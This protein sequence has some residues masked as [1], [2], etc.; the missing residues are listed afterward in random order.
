ML[1]L[2]LLGAVLG[3]LSFNSE[4]AAIDRQARD[5]A[6]FS[7]TLV[8][9]EIAANQRSVQMV[10]QSPAFDAAFDS[11]RFDLLSRRLLADEPSWRVLSVSDAQG[12][13]IMDVPEPIAGQP[14]GR[15]VDLESLRRAVEERVPVVG[16]VVQGPKGRRAFAVRAPVIRECQ[17][18]YVVSAVNLGASTGR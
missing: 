15:V 7:A 2:V 14:R 3:A 11:E 13:R 8:A 12:T 5:W 18:R 1:P 16:S 10:T 17:V 4:K 9:R 6:R